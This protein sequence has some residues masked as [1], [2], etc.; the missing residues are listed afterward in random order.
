[1]APF[2]T[3]PGQVPRRIEIERKKRLFASQ[4]LTS[5]LKGQ[6]IDYSKPAQ[7]TLHS[8]SKAVSHIPLEVFDNEE[9]E[10]RTPEEWMRLGGSMNDGSSSSSAIGVPA[11]ALSMDNNGVGQWKDVIVK[12]WHVGQEKYE[13]VW[14]DG[15]S[16]S[17]NNNS[18]ESGASK[19][20]LARMHICFKAEDPF[21]FVERVAEAHRRRQD[22]EMALL[23]NFYVDAMPVDTFPDMDSQQIKR[24]LANALCTKGLVEAAPETTTIVNGLRV[25]AGRTMNKMAFDAWVK[26]NPS[27]SM[28][29]DLVILSQE[30]S[31]PARDSLIMPYQPETTTETIARG[32]LEVPATSF[33]EKVH[34]FK[35]NSFLTKPELIKVIVAL[36]SECLKLLQ[37]SFYSIITKCVRL[38]EFINIQGQMTTSVCQMV[39]ETWPTTVHNHIRFHLKDLKKGWFNME[40]TNNEVYNF[41]KLRKFLA[42]VNFAMQDTVRF[43]VEDSLTSYSQ[44]LIKACDQMAII[45]G[46][47]KVQLVDAE[48]SGNSSSRLPLF[49][50]DL[51]VEGTGPDVRIAYS[52]SPEAFLEA[53]LACF[54][55]ALMQIQN[56]VRVER[57]VSVCSV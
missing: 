44:F 13:V 27:H 49:L 10:E 23:Y 14:T 7:S 21:N 50:V 48:G 37:L 46:P 45:S 25:Q 53:P 54:D 47:S 1:M 30:P 31:M 38:E 20:L 18:E 11:K 2:I 22:A 15:A 17:K 36:R 19:Q 8:I 6:G 51:Q 33:E 39:K 43:L 34:G 42:F 3:R 28:L 52:T 56:I 41:S 57:K 9:Y 12:A 4:D 29:Q 24:I 35:F 55:K 40:E 5:L 16:S 32:L 26:D